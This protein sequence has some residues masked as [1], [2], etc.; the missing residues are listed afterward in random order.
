MKK[1]FYYMLTVFLIMF[2]CSFCILISSKPFD[3]YS[4]KKNIEYLSSDTLKGRLPGTEENI[5]AGNFIKDNFIKNGLNPLNNNYYN[6]F[7]AYYPKKLAKKPYLKVLDENN[8]IVKEYSYSKNYKEDL[9]NFR[10]NKC[11]F[12][13]NSKLYCSNDFILA[14]CKNGS[15]LFYTPK[16]NNLNFRSSFFPSSKFDMY[17]MITSETKKE[18]MKFLNKGYCIECFIPYEVKDTVL[19][20]VCAVIPGKSKSSPVVISGHFDHLG[21]DLSNTI[22]PGALDNAS[23]ICFVMELSKYIKSL[24]TPDRDIIFI[25]FNGEEFGCI[26]SKAF[27]K[28]YRYKLKN[29]KAFNF[30]MIGSDNY[31]PLSIMGGKN[32]SK[33]SSMIK[34]A[35]SCCSKKGVPFNYIFQ[36]SSDHESFRNA[37]IDAI[38]FID[39]DTSRIHTPFDKS[40]FI[41]VNAIDRCFKV[42]SSEILKVAFYNTPFVA[43]NKH[44]LAISLIGIFT[45]IMLNLKLKENM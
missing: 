6:N 13:K 27:V 17:V 32:D 43:Y 45:L 34:S 14:N 29:S 31:P 23:G 44:F 3:S 5:L 37:G 39:D 36:N 38:T 8:A 2:Y 16:D 7:T 25:G 26:G 40:C 1:I 11:V 10:N 19:S 28:N 15:F 4:V 35:A 42:S 33:N 30:D 18:L 22:Y 20:N 24:G 21:V 41:S 12:D 9:L